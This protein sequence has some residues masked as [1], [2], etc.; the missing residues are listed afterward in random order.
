MTAVEFCRE[1]VLSIPLDQFDSWFMSKHPQSF[2]PRAIDP[3][4][5][6]RSKSSIMLKT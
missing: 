4:A 3:D 1:R 2:V 6:K 5:I